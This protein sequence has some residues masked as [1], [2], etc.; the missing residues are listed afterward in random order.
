MAITRRKRSKQ[1]SLEQP[2]CYAYASLTECGVVSIVVLKTVK[3]DDWSFYNGRLTDTMPGCSKRSVSLRLYLFVLV[4]AP[5]R[6]V[7]QFSET[8]AYYFECESKCL[9]VVSVTLGSGDKSY[10][11]D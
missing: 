4:R 3:E 9:V 6:R 11:I 10:E 2:V 5:R 7:E 8:I 1:L